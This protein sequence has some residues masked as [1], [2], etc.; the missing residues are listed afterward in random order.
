MQ[1]YVLYNVLLLIQK[2]FVCCMYTH[3]KSS[4][5]GWQIVFHL[6]TC[7]SSGYCGSGK[8]FCSYLTSAL[9][10]ERLL[11]LCS[12]GPAA[13]TAPA[14]SAAGAGVARV[15]GAGTPL[16][17][18]AGDVEGPATAAAATAGVTGKVEACF[19]A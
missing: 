18:A 9:L 11:P 5:Q 17:S 13:P 15:G 3:K 16:I 10:D 7:K 19:G 2:S 4:L 6:K 12:G 8:N 1:S 14:P